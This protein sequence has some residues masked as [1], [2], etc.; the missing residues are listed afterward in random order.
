MQN[1]RHLIEV[2]IYGLVG[3]IAWSCQTT[4]YILLVDIKIFPSVAMIFGYLGGFIVAYLGHVKYTFKKERF[5]HK[6]FTKYFIVAAIGLVLNVSM[7]RIITKVLLL[8][9]KLAIIPTLIT[10][11]ITFL[12]SKFW[13]FK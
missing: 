12:I 13:A 4:L 7:V 9:P 3:V 10:P 8:N 1:K 5:H 6:E 11:L 2:V